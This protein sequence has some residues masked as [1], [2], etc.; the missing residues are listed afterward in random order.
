MDI[1]PLL[2][3]IPNPGLADKLSNDVLFELFDWVGVDIQAA[4]AARVRD[5]S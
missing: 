1:E 3:P 5:N 4:P 2:G